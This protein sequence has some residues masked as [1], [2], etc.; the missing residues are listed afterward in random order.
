[1]LLKYKPTLRQVMFEATLRGAQ[2]PCE[3][4]VNSLYLDFYVDLGF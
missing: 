3:T 1:M 4:F 2:S